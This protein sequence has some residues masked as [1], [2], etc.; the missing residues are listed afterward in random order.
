[1]LFVE[2]YCKVPDGA[3]VGTQVTLADFQQAFFYSIYDNAVPTRE[4]I[5]SMG[6]K[7]AKTA[8]IAFIVLIHTVGPEAQRNSEIASGALARKQAAQV[9]RYAT[10]VIRQDPRL[11]KLT[12]IIDSSNMIVGIPM[13]VTYQALA[14]EAGTAMGGSP[15]LTIIDE[16]GQVKGETNDFFD[17][18]TTGQGA[19]EAPLVITISTQAPTD[20]DYLSIQIDDATASNDPA[21]VC[22]VYEAPADCSLMDRKGWRAANPAL[23]IFRSETDLIAQ[24]TKASR[25]PSKENA[26]RNLL[27]NQRVERSSPFVSRDLW[28]AN[29]STALIPPGSKV[30][31]GLDL[32]Q[33]ADLT[34]LVMIA[35][36]DELWHVVPVFWLP[37]DGLTDKAKEDRVPYDR[38]HK[39]GLLEAAPGKTV[40]YEFVAAYIADV[41]RRY[42]VQGAAFDDWKFKDLKPKL[43]AE[44]LT[45][46]DFERWHGFR[47]GFKSMS[48]AL[49]V[50]EGDLLNNRLAHGNHPVLAFCAANAVVQEDPAQNRKLIKL[51]RKRRIDGM[52]AL[53]MA[54]SLAESVGVEPPSV[55]E[56]RGVLV[57]G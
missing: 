54:R 36:I 11:V 31:L 33:V 48:P 26:A 40:D 32:S 19:H 39:E 21:I 25:M 29:G 50:L 5:L 53:V 35:F 30:W 1:M 49:N 27:L 13:N 8:T 12:K 57:F 24:M 2:E 22:H 38:W 20:A 52:I 55:Y 56:D 46:E 42:D 41:W 51:S 37:K 15:I 45:E 28:K 14:A 10:K 47:Q 9:F 44:G 6:R 7:N 23:G 34:A 16:A 3:L 17:A 18:I 4:A 43:E